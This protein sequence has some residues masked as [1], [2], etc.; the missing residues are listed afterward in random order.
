MHFSQNGLYTKQNDLVAKLVKAWEK[1]C[2]SSARGRCILMA[3]TLAACGSDDDTAS[4]DTTTVSTPTATGGT[5][6]MTPLTDVASSTTAVSGSIAST[7]RFTST[8]DTVNAITA[9]IQAADTLLDSMD[10]TMTY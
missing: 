9:S 8:D 5:F 3:L 6:D 4:T 2:E 10:P 1:K 7:F